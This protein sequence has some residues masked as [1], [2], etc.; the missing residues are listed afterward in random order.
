[1]NHTHRVW[2]EES[3]LLV[4]GDIADQATVCVSIGV[5]AQLYEFARVARENVN[6]NPNHRSTS[7]RV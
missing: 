4:L 5:Y 6:G 3:S 1:M 2:G 7:Y